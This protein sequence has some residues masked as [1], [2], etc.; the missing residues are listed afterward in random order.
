MKYL[1]VILLAAS[2]AFS[3]ATPQPTATLIQGSACTLDKHDPGK[4]NCYKSKHFVGVLIP[5]VN[6]I[7]GKGPQDYGLRSFD[8]RFGKVLAQVTPGEH[9]V[10]MQQVFTAGLIPAYSKPATATFTAV[11]GHTYS[12][13]I[14]LDNRTRHKKWIPLI[15]DETDN[16]MVSLPQPQWQ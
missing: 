15:Y 5:L 8:Y 3:E 7:D 1:P 16:R 13:N 10:Q 11:P 9:T 6:L 4:L 2:T 12:A 14:L